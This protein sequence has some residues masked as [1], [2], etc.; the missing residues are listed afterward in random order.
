M[1]DSS[2]PPAASVRTYSTSIRRLCSTMTQ[3]GAETVCPSIWFSPNPFSGER[4]TASVDGEEFA[5][6]IDNGHIKPAA[7]GSGVDDAV[8]RAM[9]NGR[10][11]RIEGGK[12]ALQ[13]QD[14]HSASR[15]PASPRPFQ[16]MADQCQRPTLTSTWLGGPV[17]TV[18]AGAQGQAE[19]GVVQLDSRALL[20]R[21]GFPPHHLGSALIHLT[22]LPL[23]CAAACACL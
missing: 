8:M 5:L 18:A 16:H 2:P 10:T 9:R 11:L 20:D 17:T 13:P 3:A 6:Q 21:R 19:G 23:T 22:V 4:I 7:S 15:S 12:P 1:C 14:Q